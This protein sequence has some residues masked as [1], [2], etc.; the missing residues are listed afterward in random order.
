[1][2]TQTAAA[3]LTRLDAAG[4]PCGVVKPV[5][6]ALQDADAS[7]LTGVSPAAPGTVRRPPPRLD[8]QG[9]LVRAQ[10]WAAFDA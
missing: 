5:L 8:E 4:V 3:W 1:V 6:E 2:R 9:A 10:G 7:P